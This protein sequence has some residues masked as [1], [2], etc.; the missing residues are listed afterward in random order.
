MVRWLEGSDDDFCL[1]TLGFGRGYPF[2]ELDRRRY[3]IIFP[4]EYSLLSDS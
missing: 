3:S 2:A 1:F 4:T